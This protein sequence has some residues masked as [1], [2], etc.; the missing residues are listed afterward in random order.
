MSNVTISQIFVQGFSVILILV[1]TI[2]SIIQRRNLAKLKKKMKK[3]FAFMKKQIGNIPICPSALALQ[4]DDIPEEVKREIISRFRQGA[5]SIKIGKSRPPSDA[6]LQIMLERA[7]AEE[8]YPLVSKIQAE[9]NRRDA[10]K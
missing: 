10:E 1:L 5:V 8:D 2:D 7:L 6:D 9:I 4:Q 3:G